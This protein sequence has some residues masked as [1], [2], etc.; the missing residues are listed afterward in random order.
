MPSVLVIG[1]GVVGAAIAHTLARRGARVSVIDMRGPGRGAS[2]A[3]AGI[4]APFTEGHAGEALRDLGARSLALWDA[5]AAEVE[6]S[7]GRPVGF[8]RIG[9]LEVALDAGDRDRLRAFARALSAGGVRHEWI[10]G[11]AVAG[12]EPAVTGAAHGALA[13][14]EHAMVNVPALV[15]ALVD[16]ARRQG[17]VFS[18]PV[19][20]AAIAHDQ[21]GVTVRTSSDSYAA[22]FVVIAS[23]S[24]SRRVRVEHVAA[25][26]V[27]P[28]RGE[29][30]HLRWPDAEPPRRV[31]WGPGCYLV[32]WQDGTVLLGATS[33]EAGFDESSTVAGVEGLLHAARALAPNSGRAS[34]VEIRVGLRPALPDGLPAI[35]PLVRAPRV[36]SATGHYRNGAL[37]APITAE[38]VAAAILDGRVDA[39]GTAFLPDRFLP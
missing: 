2:Q 35:G 19:E 22:D 20:A 1:A 16:G 5:F 30:L 32:P 27:R 8:R 12:L 11:A 26:P 29:L 23:G 37:L 7:S 33:E 13:I 25:L 18:A 38:C 31:V 17:A 3:S 9:T 36:I 21:D 14:A 15:S 28:V 24:W 4:L 39:A 6:S 10:A 34:V